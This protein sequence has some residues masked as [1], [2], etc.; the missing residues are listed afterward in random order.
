MKQKIA[1]IP[2]SLPDIQR[3]Y[4]TKVFKSIE[5]LKAMIMDQNSS[6]LIS[7]NFLQSEGFELEVFLFEDIKSVRTEKLPFV[8]AVYF[9]NAT[10]DNLKRIFAEL[11]DPNFK[12]YHFF[13]M[14][15]ISDDVIRNMAELDRQNLIKNLSRFYFN[16]HAPSNECFHAGHKDPKPN[17][18]EALMIQEVNQSEEA[19]LSVFASLRK[20]PSIRYVRDS[21]VGLSLAER[22]N[23]KLKKISEN[24]GNE[25]ESGQAVLLIVERKEDAI[26]PLLFHWNYMSLINE[27]LDVKSNRVRVEGKDFN[28]SLQHDDFYRDNMWSNY[29]DLAQALTRKLQSLSSRK[30]QSME[31]KKFEDM[32][33]LLGELPQLNKESSS[34]TKHMTI[35]NEITLQVSS[36]NLLK[37]SQLEQ[38]IATRD[39]PKDFM[40]EV[41]DIFAL[42]GPKL[43]DKF[44]LLVLFYFRFQATEPAIFRT[45]QDEFFA[46]SGAEEYISAFT[47][48]QNHYQRSKRN[49]SLLLPIGDKAFQFYK[50]M[51]GVSLSEHAQRP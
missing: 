9:V 49:T 28:L 23:R 40:K 18:P 8:S 48:V 37:I 27:L 24:F 2:R 3:D 35:M 31:V 29:G 16:Y 5:G 20:L 15:D 46:L 10:L 21:A 6:D 7:V 32:Q 43:S 14:S 39:R 34:V 13:F 12:D 33:R 42:K 11:K 17:S 38:E 25:F 41:S 45:L 4:L 30:Q 19:L 50:E 44:R 1:N 51:F 26:T 36:R 47:T 22:I